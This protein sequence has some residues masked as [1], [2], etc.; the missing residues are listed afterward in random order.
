MHQRNPV[1]PASGVS[2]V[3]PLAGVEGR[4]FESRTKGANLGDRAMGVGRLDRKS[5]TAPIHFARRGGNMTRSNN[6]ND[7][8]DHELLG[9][10][11]DAAEARA[12]KYAD[13][14]EYAAEAAAWALAAR[15]RTIQQRL[16][17]PP[18]RDDSSVCGG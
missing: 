9:A 12:V 17:E 4:L 11:A 3:Q 13:A 10:I 14:R 7:G 18:V 6:I 16:G 5:A 8:S 15:I 1:Q 2:Y